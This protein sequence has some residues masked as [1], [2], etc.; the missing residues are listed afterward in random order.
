MK[1]HCTLL[2]LLLTSAVFA[3]EPLPRLPWNPAE[4]PPPPKGDDTFRF[5]VMSDMNSSYGSTEYNATVHASIRLVTDVFKPE[6]VVS[7][8]DLVAGQKRG[9]SDDEIYAMWRG[10]D[11]AVTAPLRKAGIPFAPVPGNHDAS[12]YPA[13][14]RERE[15]YQE[16]WR[17]EA[18]QQPLNF[19]DAEHYPLYYTFEHKGVF[20]MA[21][22]V[23]TVETLPAELWAWMERQLSAAGDMKLRVAM[24]HVP[25][26][27]VAIGREKEIIRAPDNDRLR[28]LFVKH[29]VDVF[30]TGHH[31]AYFKGRKQGLNLVS[32]N[33]CGNGPRPLIGTEAPQPQSVIVVDVVDGRLDGVFAVQ[34]DGVIFDDHALPLR[35]VYQQ[36]ILPRFDQE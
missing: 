4:L 9:L 25:P 29:R 30:F 20:F 28:E 10:F 26:Y 19:I 15:I 35:L 7:A 21:M 22:D 33:A 34:H 5:V 11:R 12:G 14:A 16:V 17:T 2:I 27:P 6:L 1:H 36:Y 3:A 13:F 24:C 31:H 8:G 32:L 18:M 23:T